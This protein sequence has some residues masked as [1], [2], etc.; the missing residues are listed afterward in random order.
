MAYSHVDYQKAR[1]TQVGWN[2]LELRRTNLTAPMIRQLDSDADLPIR[3]SISCD[4]VVSAGIMD[5]FKHPQQ[6]RHRAKGAVALETNNFQEAVP[7]QSGS[8][9]GMQLYLCKRTQS[10]PAR[11]KYE[12]SRMIHGRRSKK[13]RTSIG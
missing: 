9:S 6:Q 13:R 10:F 7:H 4:W 11:E 12:E 3:L 2:S 8:A 5:R 1:G